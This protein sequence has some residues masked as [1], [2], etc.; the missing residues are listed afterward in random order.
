MNCLTFDMLTSIT[1]EGYIALTTHYVDINC[2]FV[3]KF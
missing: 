2:K 1:D 3:V